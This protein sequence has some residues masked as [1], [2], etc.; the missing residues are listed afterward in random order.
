MRFLAGIVSLLCVVNISG[1][2]IGETVPDLEGIL[3]IKGSAPVFEKQY[4]VI[5]FWSTWCGVC[6]SEFAH[7]TQI[8]AFYGD[9]VAVVGLSDEPSSDIAR[10]VR[11]MGEN[12]GYAIGMIP[13]ALRERYMK[14]VGGIPY[15]FLIKPGGD[16]IWAGHP[17]DL[18]DIL[19]RALAGTLDFERVKR[20]A[21]LEKTLK[22]TLKSGNLETIGQAADALLAVDPNHESGLR[23][24]ATVAKRRGDIASYRAVYDRIDFERLGAEKAERL[25]REL[26]N[27]NRLPFRYLKTALKLAGHALKQEPDNGDLAAIYAQVQYGLCRIGEAVKWQKKAVQSDPKNRDFAAVLQF[28]LEIESMTKEAGKTGD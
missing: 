10:Y 5:E 8:Q 1:L 26:L 19:D 17:R 12:A 20:I 6:R 3:W 22:E 4:T 2:N 15:A 23:V 7:L 28:Y 9:K 24:R 13:K 27:E 16:L 11:S 21:A 25:A 18:D 14:G